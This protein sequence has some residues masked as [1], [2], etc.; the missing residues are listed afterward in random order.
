MYLLFLTNKCKKSLS[1]ITKNKK[2][3]KEVFGVV[4]D[5][6]LSG[7]QLPIKYKAHKLSGDYN[8]CY[9]CHIQNDILFVYTFDDNK[10]ILLGI[11]IGTHS[12]LF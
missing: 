8:G 10:L 2:F 1:K 4:L 5:M 6:L 3:K 9:E 11:D 7:E 12:E